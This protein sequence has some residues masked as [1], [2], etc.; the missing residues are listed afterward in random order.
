MGGLAVGLT[1]L[2]VAKT[3]YSACLK[4]DTYTKAAQARTQIKR[5][6]CRNVVEQKSIARRYTRLICK[7]SNYKQKIRLKNFNQ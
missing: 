5:V 7:F 2:A 3:V 6:T 4:H 1:S